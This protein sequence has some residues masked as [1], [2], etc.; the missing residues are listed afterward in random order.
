MG[1]HD[2]RI[3]PPPPT[4]GGTRTGRVRSASCFN[5]A[6]SRSP[7]RREE[8]SWHHREGT[9]DQGHRTVGRP[10][11][12]VSSGPRRPLPRRRRWWPGRPCHPVVCRH[13]TGAR[14]IGAPG[15]DRDKRRTPVGRCRGLGRRGGAAGVGPHPT[16]VAARTIT[17][18]ASPMLFAMHT[19][20]NKRFP[21]YCTSRPSVRRAASLAETFGQQ[22][23]EFLPLFAE[24]LPNSLM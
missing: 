15:T 10:G 9:S 5:G 16:A 3:V 11:H 24:S 21:P 14:H 6:F 12:G 13:A 4:A 23:G 1:R 20:V 7:R 18:M 19:P 8:Q 22:R 17:A 2:G